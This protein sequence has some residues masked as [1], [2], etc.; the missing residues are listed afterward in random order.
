MLKS[1]SFV[2][3]K[4]QNLKKLKIKEKENSVQLFHLILS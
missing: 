2:L 4:T 1:N 3:K